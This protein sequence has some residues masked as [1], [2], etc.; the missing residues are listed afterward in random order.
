MLALQHV[1]QGLALPTFEVDTP[2][3]G[4]EHE[5]SYSIHASTHFTNT[6]LNVRYVGLIAD[7]Q[8]SITRMLNFCELRV[9][10]RLPQFPRIVHRL[11]K[12]QTASVAGETTE[13]SILDELVSL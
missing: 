12:L 3:L 2:I 10:V 1:R 6:I 4:F 8:S 9:R 11:V 7:P 13:L 5:I